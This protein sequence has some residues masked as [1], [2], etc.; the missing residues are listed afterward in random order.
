ED[1]CD[2]TAR[3]LEHLDS[4]KGAGQDFSRAHG[5]LA[6]RCLAMLWIGECEAQ[7]A[8]VR[9]RV[10]AHDGA[11]RILRCPDVRDDHLDRAFRKLLGYGLRPGVELAGRV[12]E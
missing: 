10:R 4:G 1:A 7:E 2:E 5:E 12:R 9:S 8:R 6:L 3:I 11:A